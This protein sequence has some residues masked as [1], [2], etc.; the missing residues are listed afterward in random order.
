MKKI[1]KIGK[2]AITL[3]ALVITIIIILILAGVTL[4]IL[5]GENGLFAKTIKTKEMYEQKSAKE[6]LEL[7]LKE[8]QIDKRANN[9]YNN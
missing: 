3:I 9:E 1:N 7:V 4:T 5:I 8:M 6:R 2:N